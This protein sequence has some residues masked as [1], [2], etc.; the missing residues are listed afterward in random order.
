MDMDYLRKCL[1]YVFGD[2]E[3]KVIIVDH[4][5]E[6]PGRSTSVVAEKARKR[7]PDYNKV[8]V[9]AN[10]KSY[11]DLLRDV[12]KHV[13]IKTEGIKVKRIKKTA[14]GDI[15]MEVKDSDC[16][17]RLKNVIKTKVADV[18]TFHR[19]N[20]MTLHITDID[21]DVNEDQVKEEIIKSLP[22]RSIKFEVSALR[23]MNNGSLATTV[24]ISK[25]AGER[26]ARIGEL[27]MGWNQWKVR[28]RIHISRCFRCFMFGH[29]KEDCKG[30]DKSV[31]V[32]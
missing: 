16:A 26:L 1:E 2:S 20:E 6:K 27:S 21:A 25:E 18:E 28:K 5:R 31:Y 17:H 32:Y 11:A 29:R 4:T 8:I 3:C 14:N 10:G 7:P 22:G 19:T 13:N 23:Q 9:K 24:T 30:E 15:L 12:K